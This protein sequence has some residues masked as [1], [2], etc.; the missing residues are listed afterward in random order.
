[1]LAEEQVLFKGEQIAAIVAET[2]EAAIEAV[3]RVRLDLEELPAV[4]DVEEALKPGAPILKP[5]GTN[6]FDLRGPSLPPHSLRRRG[7]RVRAGRLHRRRLLR[8]RARSSTR[9]LETTG[10][11]AKPEADGRITV[12]TNTQALYFIAGQHRADP[13]GPVQQAALRGRHGGRRVRR[14]GGRDRRADRHAGGHE[15]RPAGQ[16]PVHPRG[17]DAASRPRAARGASTSRTA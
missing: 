5:W 4:F 2:E 16:V 9:R 13:A 11:V 3:S 8:T 1:M 14:Q 12:Y 10:C 6:Y 7:G 15:D 17:G